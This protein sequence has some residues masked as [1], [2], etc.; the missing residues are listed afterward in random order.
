M[1][2]STWMS[3]LSSSRVTLVLFLLVVLTSLHAVLLSGLRW[4]VENKLSQLALP[5]NTNQTHLQK[6]EPQ[7]N[8]A[9]YY[10]AA[11]GLLG[12]KESTHALLNDY[13]TKLFCEQHPDQAAQTLRAFKASLDLLQQAQAQPYCDYRIRY[14]NPL[15]QPSL[16]YLSMVRL[17]RLLAAS[18]QLHSLQQEWPQACDRA[19][20]GLRFV[21]TLEPDNSLL[22]LTVRNSQTEL[23]TRSIDSIPAAQRSPQLRQEMVLLGQE[24]TAAWDRAL[25]SEVRFAMAAYDRVSREP[26]QLALLSVDRE[27]P[28]HLPLVAYRVGGELLIRLDELNYLEWSQ[29]LLSDLKTGQHNRRGESTW[30]ITNFLSFNGTEIR[31]RIQE[32]VVELDRLGRQ[33]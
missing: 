4:Q 6:G 32:R 25:A 9:P 5:V 31:Q 17:C 23:L 3:R 24:L 11:Y 12:P 15:D 30:S 20:Q 8:A 7:D 29:T 16:D 26:S 27:M 10:Q 1:K 14:E 13:D 18:T 28:W 19:V 21:R 33:R 2:F 22:L